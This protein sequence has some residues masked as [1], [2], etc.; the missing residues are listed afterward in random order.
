M[1]EKRCSKCKEVKPL[2]EFAVDRSAKSGRCPSCKA[3][4]AAYRKQN[5][6]VM[7]NWRAA[8]QEHI[9]AYDANYKASGKTREVK[10]RHREKYRE[11]IRLY[12]REY[13]RGW[14]EANRERIRW[15]HFEWRLRNPERVNAY[16]C[17]RRGKRRDT[18]RN[19][20]HRRRA[21]LAGSGGRGVNAADIQLMR[22]VQRGH[23]AY[24]QRDMAVY[25]EHLDHII[26]VTRG[27]PHEPENCCLACPKCNF[28]KNNK[29][30]A[31]WINRWYERKDRG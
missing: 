25:G 13:Q 12:H 7:R 6:D 20:Q 28:S 16:T 5:P 8:N 19:Y 15:M 11:Q 24:C 17:Q 18:C 29:T 22:D 31:E 2:E 23:C 1:S 21:L 3:C 30:P 27:G 9:K 10:R 26:P 14:R 4:Q